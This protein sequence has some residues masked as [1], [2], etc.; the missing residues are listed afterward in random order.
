VLTEIQ[1]NS[2]S[3][4]NSQL[5]ENNVMN[6]N[7]VRTAQPNS[8]EIEMN[9]QQLTSELQQQH[10]IQSTTGY[11]QYNRQQKNDLL[12]SLAQ[13][14]LMLND[15]AQFI[16]YTRARS[17]QQPFPPVYNN[18]ANHNQNQQQ[19]PSILN[20]RADAQYKSSTPKRGRPLN[21]SNGST[22]AV[23]KQQKTS[24]DG[25]I[26]A[27]ISTTTDQR[28][29]KS[30]PF[31]QLKRAVSSNLP[32]FFIEFEQ[33]TIS[34]QP[35]SAFEAR[36][37]I[38]KH[39]REHDVVIQQFSLVGWSGKRLKL[40]VN[41]KKDYM[42]LVTTEKWPTTVKNIPVKITK[43]NYVPDC[44]ALVV[45]YV[46]RDLETETVKEEIKRTISSADNVKQIHYAYER[47]S[48]DFRFTVTD[49]REYNE[50]L[51]LGRISVCNHWLTIT[52]FLSGN[53]MTYCTKCWLIGHVRDQC[54]TNTQRC[55][56]CLEEVTRKEEH[57]CSNIAKCA[58]CD[59][60]HHSLHS[61]CHV[62]QKYRTELREDVTKA[63]ESGKL[64]RN[65]YP[66]QQ[67]SSPNSE[68]FSP[69]NELVKPQ[70][71]QQFAWNRTQIETRNNE[72]SNVTQVLEIINENLVAV[73]ESNRRVE[74]RLE[75][76][77]VRVNQTA[78]DAELHQVTLDKMIENVQAL[79]EHVLWPLSRQVKPDLLQSSKGL[80]SILTNICQLKSSLRDDYKIR[81]K[82]AESP[83]STHGTASEGAISGASSITQQC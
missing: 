50:A 14:P 49:L 74:E 79:I 53:R 55:R 54:K 8:Y 73:R 58:Q 43:P 71:K 31:D 56:V 13:N 72:A 78:L 65:I 11:D 20:F 2:M 68:E 22:S 18:L 6:I 37:V 52:A 69:V 40:G 28:T 7:D 9:E 24:Q 26:E 3:L 35:P 34:H 21:D 45:R 38:E 4:T 27:G 42:T 17:I 76:I 25:P 67:S 81:R 75:K 39:F 10:Y 59:G 30:L 5:A 77:D 64:Q 19:I 70:R 12:R 63:V 60:E 32:C 61:Q 82:R 41:N 29:R 33:S 83:P 15:F 23:P 57:N 46:P 66:K 62:I 1:I 80:Q 51:E 36:S 16:E 48:N 47:R 44:F